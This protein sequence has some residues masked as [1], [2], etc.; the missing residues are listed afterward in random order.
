M[1]DIISR[2]KVN[3]DKEYEILGSM[4]MSRKSLAAAYSRYQNGELKRSH[5]SKYYQTLFEI[6]MG[7]YKEKKTSPESTMQ[8][9][10][11]NSRELFDGAAL[12][13]IESSIDRLADEYGESDMEVEYVC[14]TMLPQFIREREIIRRAALI[15]GLVEKGKFSEAEEIISG[16]KPVENEEVEEDGNFGAILPFTI[17]DVEDAF[18]RSNITDSIAY[19]FPGDLGR[20]VGPLRKTWFVAVS[21]VEKGGKSYVLNEICY[22]AVWNQDKKALYLNLELAKPLARARN[23]RR[24]SRTATMKSVMNDPLG[25][26]LII[27]IFD[28]M[29]NQR[30]TCGVRSKQNNKRPLVSGVVVNSSSY[31]ANRNWKVCTQCRYS[32]TFHGTKKTERFIPSIWFIEGPTVRPTNKRRVMKAINDHPIDYRDNFR[33]QCFPSYTKTFDD[34]QNYIERYIEDTNWHPDIIIIDYLDILYEDESRDRRINI[35]DNWKKAK[36]L[37]ANMNCLVITADQA[38]KAERAAWRLGPMSTSESKTKDGHI[39]IRIGVHRT[40]EE[41]AMGV[42]RANIIFHRHEDY[43]TRQDVLMTQRLATSEPYMDTHYAEGW[44]KHYCAISR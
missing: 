8:K 5:F 1:E 4:I 11:T 31:M 17:E 32:N 33:I 19:Q 7:W 41:K 30:N 21:G 38:T 16:Y 42:A 15:Q 39:D 36:R 27:P 10:F 9:L 3:I 20:M 25:R 13:L 24:I 23:H 44:E 40:D 34:C 28:C 2:Q 35:D 12:E 37:A 22:D 6:L 18:D 26:Q 29:N 14:N 43:D